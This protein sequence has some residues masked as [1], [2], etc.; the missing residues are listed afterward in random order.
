MTSCRSFGQQVE[1]PDM[2]ISG[3]ERR[4]FCPNIKRRLSNG[5]GHGR[6]RPTRPSAKNSRSW[7]VKSRGHRGS[8]FGVWTTQVAAMVTELV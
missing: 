5:R 6:G 1:T 3:R 4:V 7:G 8:S 2:A